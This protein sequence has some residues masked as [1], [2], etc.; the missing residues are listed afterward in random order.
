L[1]TRELVAAPD[2][3]LFTR[4]LPYIEHPLPSVSCLCI[5]SGYIEMLY[6]EVVA[7]A[8]CRPYNDLIANPVHTLILD[9]DH[10]PNLDPD[11][12]PNFDPDHTLNLD[13]V[14]TPD[15]TA[16]LEPE[17]HMSWASLPAKELVQRLEKLDHVDIIKCIVDLPRSR[18]PVY[19]RKTC[20]QCCVA[21]VQHIQQR[22]SHLQ[23]LGNYMFLVDVLGVVPFAVPGTREYLMSIVLHREY[24]TLLVNRLEQLVLPLPERRKQEHKETKE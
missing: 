17:P 18:Q 19:A 20:R 24:S 5:I 6:G 21:L 8:L 22:V 4:Y 14:H 16:K 12:T 7:A 13:P 3:L 15:H 2:E 11:H 9:P 23:S 1:F 10:T